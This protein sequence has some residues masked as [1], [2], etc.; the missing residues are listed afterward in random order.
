MTDLS[1]V[2]G[3]IWRLQNSNKSST[4]E[5]FSERFRFLLSHNLSLLSS[6]HW[7]QARKPRSYASSKLRLTY[8]LT[9]VKF[10]STSVTKKCLATEKY[11]IQKVFANLLSL[12]MYFQVAWIFFC[13]GDLQPFQ[14]VHIS[15]KY[16][17]MLFVHI[18]YVQRF[19]IVDVFNFVWI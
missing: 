11:D 2:T 18:W 6:L 3:L 14:H 7:K 8:S 13:I 17:H 15:N 10:R 12:T 4:F 9:G 16:Q 1:S 5:L 19:Q